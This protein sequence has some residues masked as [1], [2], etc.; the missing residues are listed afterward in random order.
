[1]IVEH[2]IADTVGSFIGKYSGRIRISQQQETLIEAPLLHLRSVQVLSH[3]VSISADALEACCEE[4]VPVFFMDSLGRCYASVY[5]AGLGATVL[6]R[7]QQLLA[8]L[9]G[10]GVAI[11]KAVTAAK[12]HNQSATLKYMAKNRKDSAPD[13]HHAL[14]QIATEIEE[15]R[16]EVAHLKGTTVDEVRDRIMGVEGYAAQRYWAAVRLIVPEQYGWTERQHRG[17]NDPINSLLNYGYGILYT[18]IEQ[19]LVLAGLDPYA[20]FLHADRPGK[21]SLV[22]DF[23]EEFRQ[24]AVDRVV[25]GLAT[26]GFQVEQEA[27]GKL[28]SA[29]RRAL[30]EHLLAHGEATVRYNGQRHVLRAVIQSQAR[31]M[32]AYL[33][34]ETEQYGAYAGDW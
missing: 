9:D 12:L 27:D 2:L 25:F 15:A 24:I 26:R 32:A 34:A 3:G 10:R 28:T 18:R 22:L 20:G 23:I 11:A 1:M 17:A 13:I 6:T 21:P 7:R 19:A 5:A 31:Q 29:T 33:R 8:Y 16:D 14:R 4:G 30:A